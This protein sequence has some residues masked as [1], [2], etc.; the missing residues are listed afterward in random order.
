MDENQPPPEEEPQQHHDSKPDNNQDQNVF[1]QQPNEFWDHLLDDENEP[2]EYPPSDLSFAQLQKLNKEFTRLVNQGSDLDRLGLRNTQKHPLT[3]Q[4]FIHQY[5]EETG[6][7]LTLL[8][9]FQI[10]SDPRP[11]CVVSLKQSILIDEAYGVDIPAGSHSRTDC[12]ATLLQPLKDAE[13]IT[14]TIKSDTQ[15]GKDIEGPILITRGL[16]TRLGI[17]NE[18]TAGQIQITNVHS[19]RSQIDTSNVN[20]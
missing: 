6:Q 15:F 10:N 20:F 2:V 1:E 16:A 3:F 12:K 14:A 18:T 9:P 5:H 4:E 13:P 17:A 11:G 8:V 19:D 7:R